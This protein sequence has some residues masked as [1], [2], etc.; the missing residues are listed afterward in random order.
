MIPIVRSP[1]QEEI[2]LDY[3]VV[4]SRIIWDSRM[5]LVK[6]YGGANINR[7]K[8]EIEESAYSWAFHLPLNTW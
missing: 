2:N 6:E 4:S 8:G 1:R 5:T 7:L 3:P